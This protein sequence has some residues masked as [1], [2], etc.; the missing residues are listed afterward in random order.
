MPLPVGHAAIGLAT[1]EVTTG[2]GTALA[3]WKTLLVIFLLANL[4]DIDVLVGLLCHNNGSIFHRGP[5][6][7]LLFA[8]LSGWGASMAWRIS[9][10]I[11]RLGFGICFFLVFSHVLSDLLLTTAPVSLLWPFE[12]NWSIGQRGW[13]D[14]FGAVFLKAF[15]DIGIIV[16]CGLVILAKQ[17]IVR[18][19]VY[20][21][22]GFVFER[23]SRETKVR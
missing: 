16:A 20:T 23:R 3:R 5:T 7:S 4:P 18:L 19:P 11:P 17:V 9:P 22:P 2:N 6:H 14:I 8:L 15:Q 1:H 13:G 21:R 10:K 12:V